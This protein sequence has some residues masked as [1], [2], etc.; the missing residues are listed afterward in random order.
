MTPTY[1]MGRTEQETQRL[2]AASRLLNPLTR[3]MLLDA[4][5]AP[6]MRVL[7]VGT[8]AGDVALLA[9]ELVGPTGSVVALDQNPDIL[10]TAYARA[11]AAGHDHVAFVAGDALDAELPGPFDAIIGR[12]VM[13][14]IGDATGAL[15]RL[16]G[17]LA[18]G[19]I[20][21]FQ[22]FNFTPDSVRVTPYLQLWHT[23]WGWMVATAER[24]G[25][26]ATAGFGLHRAM[27]D[28]GLSIPSMRLESIVETGPDAASYA[29]ITDAIRSMLPLIERFGVATA[30]EVDIDT[31]AER[32]RAET[33]A[34][35]AVLKTPD[36]V[37]A[38][39]RTP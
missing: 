11:Q 9:A 25:I 13:M 2:V 14:Y 6:G 17:L 29:W 35:D 39:T 32:L 7:D 33:V 20:V 26:P 1:L 19:G 5:L 16:S 23:A 3:R 30:A 18:P 31:L 8:G 36:V 12:L 21:A 10:Q 38:W 4:G 37:S 28:A 22:D 27:V 15:R 34:V 24:A